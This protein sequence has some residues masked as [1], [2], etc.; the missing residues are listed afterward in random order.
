MNRHPPHGLQLAVFLFIRVSVSY[1]AARHRPPERESD[2]RGEKGE[3]KALLFHFSKERENL[4][5][6]EFF[7]PFFFLFFH[8]SFY[9]RFFDCFV[10]KEKDCSIG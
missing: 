3:G 6:R 8:P 2:T 7:F 1:C 5:A 4:H 9:L 10:Y